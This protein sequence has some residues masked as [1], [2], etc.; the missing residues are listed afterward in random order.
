MR[1][2][3]VGLGSWGRRWAELV[4][5]S[6]GFQ[7]AGIIDPDPNS[8]AWAAETLALPLDAVYES[9]D[10]A[11]AHGAFDTVLVTTP[12]ETHRAVT[13]TALTAGCHVLVEKPLATSVADARAMAA[14]AERAERALMV[15]Q[16]YRYTAMARAMRAT[17]AEDRIGSVL[18][19]RI[20]FRDTR[21]LFPRGNFR[22][23]MRH[24]LVLD[25]A[26]HHFD[27]LRAIT[28][29]EPTSVDARSW[30]V[31]DSPYAHDP[32]CAALITLTGDVTAV[33]DGDWAAHAPETSWNGDWEIIGTTGRLTWRGDAITTQCWEEDPVAVPAANGPI[34][35][36]LG[37]LAE[38]AR[39]IETGQPP[40][41]GVHDN[42]NSLAV[43]LGCVAS[44][45][46]GSPVAMERF[47]RDGTSS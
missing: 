15:S 9:F 27:L 28:G 32:A 12:P 6:P 34:D 33:Y 2:L 18:A 38:F 11:L 23:S 20:A 17:I 37:V 8:R 31:P 24:P 26:I 39:A 19:V 16:N 36:R 30:R 29:R 47:S 1:L 3:Q 4:D 40:E 13:E 43:T 21:Q 10:G 45:E 46:A 7:L 44:I 42:L 5:A 14:A 22:Y 41:T 35:G 25:M